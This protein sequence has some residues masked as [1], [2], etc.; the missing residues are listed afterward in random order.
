MMIYQQLNLVRPQ[1]NPDTKEIFRWDHAWVRIGDEVVDGN[2]DSL[3]ENPLVPSIVKVA[4]YWGPIIETPT[5]RKLRE[6]R[7]QKLPDDKDVSEIWW[8]ELLIWLDNQLQV[9]VEQSA[10]ADAAEPRR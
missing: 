6:N 1:Y 3:F 7:G 4:P 2:V 10:P 9:C 5:D 8:P